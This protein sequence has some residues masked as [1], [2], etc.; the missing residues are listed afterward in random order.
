[1]LQKW[2]EEKLNHVQDP[3][4]RGLSLSMKLNTKWKP[5]RRRQQH[6]PFNI[7]HCVDLTSLAISFSKQ[8]IRQEMQVT[9]FPLAEGVGGVKALYYEENYDWCRIKEREL[10]SPTALGLWTR[11]CKWHFGIRLKNA[12]SCCNCNLDC[13]L[14]CCQGALIWMHWVFSHS[15]PSHYGV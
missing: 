2:N 1:M 5:K 11:R 15:D 14:V 8:S 6:T 4:N 12:W 9:F 7:I 3:S 13:C 10:R